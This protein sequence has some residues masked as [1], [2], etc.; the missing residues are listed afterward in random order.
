MISLNEC[1]TL[2]NNNISIMPIGKNKVPM[3]KWKK[4]QTELISP[5][6][7]ER[8]YSSCEG[9][10]IITGYE[11][12]ECIDVDLKVLPIQ[13]RQ[14]WWDE[15][16]NMLMDH[17]DD[18][19]LKFAVYRTMSG[20]FH[21]IYKSPLVRGNTKIAKLKGM[22]EAIIETRGRG[23]YI[24]AY[25]DHVAGLEYSALAEL[26][27]SDRKILW[28]ISESYDY[29]E[30][31]IVDD[32]NPWDDYNSKTSMLSIIGSQ[33]TIVK[34]TAKVTTIKRHGAKSAWSG[35][36]FKDSGCLYLFST[37]TE[38][39]AEELINPFAAYA[40]KNHFGDFKAAAGDLYKQGFGARM[41]VAPYVTVAP[42]MTPPSED[43]PNELS[44][45]IRVGSNYFKKIVKQDRYGIDR[46]E[47]KKWNKFEIIQDYGKKSV[48][49]VKK[50]DDFTI[51][52]DNA[53]YQDEV[54]SCYNLYSAFTH[55]AIKG[56]WKWT[57]ILLEHIFGEQYGIGIIYL[58]VLYLHPKQALP[59]LGL[60]SKA[61]QTGK[62]TFLD[63]LTALFGGNMV[64]I[65]SSN[66]K[67]EFNGIY[68][69][70][71]IIGI[72]ETFIDKSSTIEKI[73]SISTQKSMTM[74][75][76]GVQHSAIPFFGKIIMNSNNEDK[77]IKIEQDEIRFFVRKIGIPQHQN[78]NILA[79]LINEIPAFLYFLKTL[80]PVDFTKSRMV[81]TVEELSNGSL[82]KVKKESRSW[83]VK[84]LTEY[85][86]DLF[87]NS[88]SYE[89]EMY[90][91][92]RD[93]KEKWFSH[94]NQVNI[95]YISQVLSQE[96]NIEQS[97]QRR[98]RPFF[99]ENEKNSKPFLFIVSDFI[100]ENDR[101]VAS[102]SDED[103]PF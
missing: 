35:Y 55:K 32:T 100:A 37:G 48:H 30:A 74:N 36:I 18:F 9:I 85:L 33:F 1:K 93:I 27:D 20:G 88:Q 89:N 4:Y 26:S 23:G 95:Y 92:S 34:E 94:N 29:K 15:Y 63:W 52:P 19:Q 75:I 11:D 6:D 103:I 62:S 47:I 83:L 5:T 76:K 39:P 102:R 71:N 14:D 25:E 90:A 40:Y 16:L 70:A 51:V 84:E 59:V 57:K 101:F 81:F 46:V 86:I 87:G 12:I 41:K 24:Y 53:N 56:D 2:I 58:Q 42:I 79:D 91:S 31:P 49:Q 50:Y 72:E 80:P 8:V 60:V 82:D 54:N 61:R 78:H 43:I 97:K 10:G 98:Y 68:A 99:T 13:E 28:S 64:I 17:I 67:S 65:D 44:A 21:I 45:Y 22:K 77:F 38:Y 66:L 3:G 73:K 69:Q 7:I 96:M